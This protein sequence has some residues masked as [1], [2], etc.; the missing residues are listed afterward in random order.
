MFGYITLA[1]TPLL[2]IRP[3]LAR[4]HRGVASLGI[5]MAALSAIAL[6]LSD[7]TPLT[8]LFQRIGLTAGQVWIA[9]SALAMAHRVPR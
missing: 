5:A 4:G 6:I 8:G 9:G 3:L 1:V 7:T 2:A